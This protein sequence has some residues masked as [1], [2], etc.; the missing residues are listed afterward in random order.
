MRC[1][2]NPRPNRLRRP[3]QRDDDGKERRVG[4]TEGTDFHGNRY[5]PGEM[6]S[7][8][9]LN[10]SASAVRPTQTRRVSEGA[11]NGRGQMAG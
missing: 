8:S 9:G 3:I 10:S 6:R 2:R 5:S 1:F 11:R 4:T 7:Y